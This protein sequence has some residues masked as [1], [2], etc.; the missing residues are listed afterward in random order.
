MVKINQCD[1]D[2]SDEELLQN[3][4]FNIRRFMR[5][6]I[7]LK[8]LFDAFVETDNLRKQEKIFS[9]LIK[10]LEWIPE[11]LFTLDLRF[12]LFVADR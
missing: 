2:S 7:F 6:H 10:W 8:S 1:R 9:V 5:P 12:I 3:F 11:D 4:L